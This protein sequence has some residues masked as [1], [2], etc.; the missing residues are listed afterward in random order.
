MTTTVITTTAE[1]EACAADW[2]ELLDGCGNPSVT[3]TWP[4]LQSWW[5]VFGDTS[6]QLRVVLVR[7]GGRLIGAAPLV[8]RLVPR[9]HYRVVSM[10]RMELMASGEERGAPICS[11]Y[12]GWP[13]LAGRED[14]VAAAVLDV[15]LGDL[16]GEWDEVVLPDMQSASPMA[17]AIVDVATARRLAVTEERREP[18]AVLD[19]APTWNAMLESLGSGLR[20][21]IRRG[22]RDFEAQGGTYHAVGADEDWQQSFETLVTL[23][24]SRWE[25]KGEPGAFKHPK[26]LAF[27]RLVLPRLLQRGWLRLGILHLPDGPLGAIYNT[28]YRGQVF[29]YQSGI[30]LTDQTHLRPGVLMHGYEIEHAISVGATTYDFLKR[31][32]SEYK[33]AWASR[34]Q[35]LVRL[36][37]AR[38][39]LKNWSYEALREG[40]ARARQIKHRME[41]RAR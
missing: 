16:R 20:Y 21:K 30:R 4:W 3:L 15:V 6:R 33:D 32:H 40:M 28:L 19:L 13:A 29:F 2:Q 34:S 31:G 39:D 9:R 1:W 36:R 18:A 8:V 17:T 25:A 26:R 10:R 24:Q 35:D 27:H 37:L 14:D 12:I 11:D 7:D 38:R 5:E 23:H 22:R 41:S